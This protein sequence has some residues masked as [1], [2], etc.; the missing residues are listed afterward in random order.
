M[1]ETDIDTL[2]ISGEVGAEIIEYKKITNSV[3]FSPQE[4]Y[5]D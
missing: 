1:R 2:I 5:T 4:N 3:A